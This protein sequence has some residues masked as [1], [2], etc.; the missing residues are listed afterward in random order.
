MYIGLYGWSGDQ[1]EHG[2]GCEW[3]YSTLWWVVW[4]HVFHFTFYGS[5]FDQL[6]FFTFSA[7]LFHY[8]VA[9]TSHLHHHHSSWSLLYTTWV[10][11]AKDQLIK[12]VAWIQI[13]AYVVVGLEICDGVSTLKKSPV[14][15]K[16]TKKKS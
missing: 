1:E 16:R 2:D 15:Q 7:I 4:L 5:L 10:K 11:A 13:F 8:F 3:L 14:H 12:W 6:Y 9:I